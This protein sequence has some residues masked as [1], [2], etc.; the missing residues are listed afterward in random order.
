MFRNLDAEQARAGLSNEQIANYLS[1]SRITYENKKKTGNFKYGEI[2][3]LL[4]LFKVKFEYLFA[5]TKETA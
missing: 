4:D 3:K 1:L 2:T 5:E